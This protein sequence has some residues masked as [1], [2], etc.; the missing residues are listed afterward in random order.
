LI[1][2]GDL[3]QQIVGSASM[4]LQ[5]V[6]V[7]LVPLRLTPQ[8]WIDIDNPAHVKRYEF[9]FGQFREG[10][11]WFLGAELAMSLVSGLLTSYSYTGNNCAIAVTASAASSTAY[12]FGLLVLKPHTALSNRIF[13]GTLAGVQAAA[14][15]TQAVSLWTASEESQKITRTVTEG[16]SM[17]VSWALLGKSL[18]SSLRSLK[19]F[20][21]A[22][23]SNVVTEGTGLT[24]LNTNHWDLTQRT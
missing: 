22:F 19:T 12:L 18:Y 7:I 14:L 9:I 15:T 11:Q 6:G 21:K 20:I 16:L 13:Y 23:E 3:T 17:T 8:S 2:E 4:A 24:S 5:A 10:R 1:R